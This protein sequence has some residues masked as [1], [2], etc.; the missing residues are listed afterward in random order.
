M[1]ELSVI[2]AARNEAGTLPAQ[3]EAVLAQECGEPWEVIVADNGSTD[4]TQD[5]VRALAARD[6]R[7]RLVDASARPGSSYARNH[8][9]LAA[10]SSSIG[11]GRP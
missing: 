9:V 3:L 5:V 2:I 8:A 7:L 4:G 1:C 11:I 6:S 10:A